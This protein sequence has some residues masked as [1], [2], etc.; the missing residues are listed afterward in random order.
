M[1]DFSTIISITTAFLLTVG[2]VTNYGFYS[3]FDIDIFTF[4][5]SSEIILSF[6]PLT[7]PLIISLFLIINYSLLLNNRFEDE[8]KANKFILNKDMTFW[9]PFKDLIKLTKNKFK[10][11]DKIGE[12]LYHYIVQI[13]A[14]LIYLVIFI[15]LTYIYI[16]A[17]VK[18]Q[19]FPSESPIT[20]FVISTIWIAM[21]SFR[22]NKYFNYRLKEISSKMTMIT[23]LISFLTVIYFYN[24]FK[25]F[26]I[27]EKSPIYSVELTF[28]D[29]IVKT[30]NKLIYIGKTKEYYFLRDLENNK[31]IV[32][33][34]R[35]IE[36]IK[37]NKIKEK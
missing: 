18:K 14:R 27:L 12:T 3:Q 31:N 5:N 20:F 26:R 34:D 10:T 35:I 25:A 7:I 22:I 9:G 16:Q 1:K 33:N 21:L 11:E 6:L 23:F 17:F 19:G 29:S 8:K 30:N 2:F 24:S 4:M 36:N 28:K 32:Y 37:I 13:F 15:G